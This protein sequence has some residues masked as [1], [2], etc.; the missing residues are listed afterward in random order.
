MVE[1]QIPSWVIPYDE[2]NLTVEKKVVN[3]YGDN[4]KV[5]EDIEEKEEQPIVIPNWVTPYKNIFEGEPELNLHTNTTLKKDT[6]PKDVKTIFGKRYDELN[7]EGWG[8]WVYGWNLGQEGLYE[9]L[10]NIPGSTDR[11]F[12]WIGEKTG[13]DTDD[14]GFIEEALQ[15]SEEWLTKRARLTNPEYQ[16]LEAPKTI[17]GKA[18]SMFAGLPIMV[19]E[20][21]PAVYFLG[22]VGGMALVDG[23]RA[24]EPN[25]GLFDIAEGAA[26]GAVYGKGLKWAQNYGLTKRMAIMSSMG[27]GGAW[28]H[29]APMEDRIANALVMGTIGIPGR[30]RGKSF[31]E[32][33]R[34]ETPGI[35]TK[36]QLDREQLKKDIDTI[37]L[38]IKNGEYPADA[39]II[40]SLLKRIPDI[41]TEDLQT[42]INVKNFET[43]IIEINKTLKDDG[44]QINVKEDGT[45]E[46]NFIDTKLNKKTDTYSVRKPLTVK[47]FEKKINSFKKKFGILEA[48]HYYNSYLNAVKLDAPPLSKILNLTPKDFAKRI[49]FQQLQLQAR[50]IETKT[51]TFKGDKSFYP[52]NKL[53]FEKIEDLMLDESAFNVFDKIKILPKYKSYL[54]NLKKSLAKTFGQE[55][56]VYRVM[57][58]S[59]FLKL[60]YSSKGI[61]KPL[62]VT[63]D[64]KIAI[65]GSWVIGK[66]KAQRKSEAENKDTVFPGSLEINDPVLVRLQINAKD[67]LFK[68]DNVSNLHEIIIDGSKVKSKNV[69]LLKDNKGDAKIK[70]SESDKVK[71]ESE[72]F[73]FEVMNNSDAVQGLAGYRSILPAIDKLHE[74]RGIWESIKGGRYPKSEYDPKTGELKPQIEKQVVDF[75]S[76]IKNLI[77]AWITEGNKN[78]LIN[79][80]DTLPSRKSRF[81]FPEEIHPIEPFML[82]PWIR[83]VLNTM[84]GKD[85]RVSNP[86]TKLLQDITKYIARVGSIF[87]R[88]TDIHRAVLDTVRFAEAGN[89][90]AIQSLIY[91]VHGFKIV[92]WVLENGKMHYK[93]EV[94]PFTGTRYRNIPL[95]RDLQNT[96]KNSVPI[97]DRGRW[98][99]R[100]VPTFIPEIIE[101]G[102]FPKEVK[103]D[104]KQGSFVGKL[105]GE[106]WLKHQEK[107]FNKI[108]KKLTKENQQ[109]ITL[110]NKISQDPLDYKGEI[111]SPDWE[112]TLYGEWRIANYEKGTG[113]YSNVVTKV[114]IESVPKQ[115]GEP[116]RKKVL[117]IEDL[118]NVTFNNKEIEG[119]KTDIVNPDG[120]L[121]SIEK[122]RLENKV[123][124]GGKFT[125]ETKRKRKK[126]SDKE[127]KAR[128]KMI[129]ERLDQ[130][131]QMEDAAIG[132]VSYADKVAQYMSG[133]FFMNKYEM[134]A[135]L[136]IKDPTFP[137]GR[138][139]KYKDA[140]DWYVD[141]FAWMFPGRF[142]DA[143][144]SIQYAMQEIGLFMNKIEREMEKFLYRA[145]PKELEMFE[146]S[147][148]IAKEGR[149]I[150]STGRVPFGV[151]LLSRMHWEPREGSL[152]MRLDRLKNLDKKTLVNG[153]QGW[154]RANEVI[155][156]AFKISRDKKNQAQK[157]NLPYDIKNEDGTFK[158]EV[159][160]IELKNVYKLDAEQIATYRD[161]RN[162]LNAL[163]EVYNGH[164]Q[165]YKQ[166]VLKEGNVLINPLPNYIPG[167]FF[168]DARIFVNRK[169]AYE[170]AERGEIEWEDLEIFHVTG[171]DNRISANMFVNSK[172]FKTKYPNANVYL[173]DGKKDRI[174]KKEGAGD[175]DV[176]IYMV[177]RNLIKGTHA[178][179]AMYEFGE[180][181]GYL[182]KIGKTKEA[183]AAE[184]AAEKLRASRG[185]SVHKL[186]KADIPGAMGEQFGKASIKDVENFEKAMKSYTEGLLRTAYGW[187]F[188]NDVGLGRDSIIGDRITKGPMKHYPNAKVII[189]RLYENATGRNV[190]AWERW[191]QDK[192]R[193]WFGERGLSKFFGGA[194]IFA[195]GTSL[196]FL[197]IRFL[198]AQFIQPYQMIT[199]T[200]RRLI[201]QKK[202]LSDNPNAEGLLM[203][204][205]LLA[206][207]RMIVPKKEDM[208]LVQFL[209]DEG[210]LEAKFFQELLS[211]DAMSTGRFEIGTKSFPTYTF[212]R[213][214]S[215]K[216]FVGRME[217]WSRL[218][219][220][221]MVYHL[222]RLSGR[223]E[224][225]SQYE[226]AHYADKYMVQYALYER[227]PI[228][229]SAGLGVFAKPVGLFKTFQFNWT[230]QL[231]EH[232]VTSYKGIQKAMREEKTVSHKL[233]ESFNEAQNTLYFLGSMILTAGLY[234][235]L[236]RE[237]IDKLFSWM[238]MKSFTQD[239][240][241][242][243]L[244]DY[245]LWGVPSAIQDVDLTTTL[246]A[247]GIGVG[248]IF[249]MPALDK[250]GINPLKWGEN[251]GIAQ[252][253]G[254]L[255]MDI[256]PRTWG[257]KDVVTRWEMQRFWKALMP[258]SVHGLIETAYTGKTP[259]D[260]KTWGDYPVQ[261]EYKKYGTINRETKDHFVRL[262]LTAR[263][264]N[265]SRIFK[266]AY[267]MTLLDKRR[268][269]GINDLVAMA[270]DLK[271]RDIDIPSWLF[272]AAQ[273]MY[274]VSASDFGSRINTRVDLAVSTLTE[275]WRPSK[276][277]G[278]YLMK[279][280]M[281]DGLINDNSKYEGK[282][283]SYYHNKYGSQIEVPDWVVPY[284]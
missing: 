79:F 38:A 186:K 265:E 84:K 187:K 137:G 257:K 147:K 7:P 34:E 184:K 82:V 224:K 250:L 15:N 101:I 65:D 52:D 110:R 162:N 194:N 113:D 272:K 120:Q 116:I 27:F 30:Y 235:I 152:L 225:F 74:E 239:L 247:P 105:T 64:N 164:A 238:G 249:S 58:R 260:F 122:V 130:I 209:H 213:N 207:K 146:Y 72:L 159:T 17:R 100:N 33:V 76:H 269:D 284:Q 3:Q 158:Y 215:M 170:K 42:E 25:A 31:W 134:L 153:K 283:G 175:Y 262:L 173:K 171:K 258:T 55:F 220:A 106:K 276:I 192:L 81:K 62:S 8:S 240:L 32:G 255:I 278:A 168:G 229:G 47:Q 6:F 218:Q 161:I 151:T 35:K 221:M 96:L 9:L 227:A 252:A 63:L 197:N 95:N 169:G 202:L 69:E 160:D 230:A 104:G 167:M 43:N 193:G 107:E 259:L 254:T 36:A 37:N 88:D 135:D 198:Q 246:A 71:L 20:Y 172:E 217:S 237:Q 114:N 201:R 97:L 59:D 132:T 156:T 109:N 154:E 211:K 78:P 241:E 273:E 4:I 228:F 271:M 182:K 279:E 99:Y 103:F 75:N 70:L 12:D 67:A 45:V 266:M 136:E 18:M 119:R 80:L 251:K 14:E 268:G 1:I 98:Q 166:I 204:A 87:R 253:T 180:V 56:F 233:R 177:D 138:K 234:G 49:I 68:G 140:P 214:A 29:G 183:K 91:K 139:P 200:L 185:F 61:D 208:R 281:F 195:L 178:F 223:S 216:S 121:I 274:N 248:D 275:R 188:I 13:L 115:I 133:R 108:I 155:Q 10:N 165:Q 89:Q 145:T 111:L 19:A 2:Q 256:I 232:A 203:D 24:A 267:A 181:I 86:D 40:T 131:I 126:L 44:I 191:V 219:A 196:L 242:S 210:V 50:Q 231:V 157:D 176:T 57:D 16:G 174:L 212:L 199:P 277:T 141:S 92:D 129:D 236:G 73:W 118:K 125:V 144:P 90:A 206:Q 46:Y 124:E 66:T 205:S 163:V 11:F 94:V 5:E 48:Q 117:E 179:D 190:N 51:Q 128:D 143:H 270:A 244:P 189:N 112:P 60:A 222:L 22:P 150:F 264:L 149:G 41:K 28:I 282:S 123:D 21:A 83:G 263:T 127:K 243:D 39:T 142:M 226:A 26:W 53:E 93:V 280:K 102:Q 245:V 23:M 85:S 77:D 54:K 148:E 261:T